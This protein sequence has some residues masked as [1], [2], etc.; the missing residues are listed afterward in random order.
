MN[1]DNYLV[2]SSW[3]ER[4]ERHKNKT[5]AVSAFIRGLSAFIRVLPFSPENR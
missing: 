5:N 4:L 1:A 2:C 3:G